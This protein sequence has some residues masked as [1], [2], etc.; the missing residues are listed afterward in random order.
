MPEIAQVAGF[1]VSPAGSA[2]LIVQFVTVPLKVGTILTETPTVRTE[3]FVP[4]AEE[5]NVRLEGGFSAELT[6]DF[7]SVPCN[8]KGHSEE[9]GEWLDLPLQPTEIHKVSRTKRYLF[10]IY[11]SF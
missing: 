4:V 11:S 6:A 5:V 1:R 2:G 3:E 7:L 10:F 9:S 8:A